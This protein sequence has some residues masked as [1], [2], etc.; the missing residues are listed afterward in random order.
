VG[1]PRLYRGRRSTVGREL[2]AFFSR[3]QHLAPALSLYSPDKRVLYCPDFVNEQQNAWRDLAK[4]AAEFSALVFASIQLTTISGGCWNAL[5]STLVSSRRTSQVVTALQ[6]IIMPGLSHR[7]AKATHIIECATF[8]GFS[9]C[10]IGLW[11]GFRW[12]HYR[13]C[14]LIIERATVWAFAVGFGSRLLISIHRA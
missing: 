12:Q 8:S 13:T 10:C 2:K 3:E 1:W 7:C 5:F 14:E 6:L 11:R 9:T 4:R